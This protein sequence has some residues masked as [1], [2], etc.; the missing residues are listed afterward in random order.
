MTGWELPEKT[1][2]LVFTHRSMS[3]LEVDAYELDMDRYQEIA[4]MAYAAKAGIEPG[5]LPSPETLLAFENL[6]VGFGEALASWNLTRRGKPV[7]ASSAALRKLPIPFVFT[8]VMAW[9]D[10]LGGASQEQA[11]AEPDPSVESRLPM[12]VT[13]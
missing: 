4:A 8:V 13:E 9:L 7:E 1:Y 6:C 5:E 3:G 11:Q 12:A 2:R 10:A